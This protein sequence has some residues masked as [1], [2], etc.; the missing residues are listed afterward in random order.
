MTP[1]DLL[2]IL[3]CATVFAWWIVVKGDYSDKG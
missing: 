2:V 1:I 3:F